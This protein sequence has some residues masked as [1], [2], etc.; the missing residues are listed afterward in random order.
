MFKRSTFKNNVICPVCTNNRG[1]LTGPPKISRQAEKFIRAGYSIV[2]CSN[3]GYYFVHPVIDLTQ[4]EWQHLY[5]DSYFTEMTNWHKKYRLL[6]IEI[7]FSKLKDYC[8]NKI[9]NYLDVGCGEGFGLLEASRRGWS[10]YGIDISDNRIEEAKTNSINFLA[11]DIF[12]AKFPDNLFDCIYMDSVLEHL[13]DPIPYLIELNRIIKKGGILYIGVPDEDSLF[14]AVKKI[15]YR[16]TGNP[17]SEK[18]KPFVT[19]YHVGGFNK[20]SLPFAASEAKFKVIELRNFAAHFEFRKYS[21]SSRNFWLHL[22]LLPVDLTA[23][24][25]GNEIYLEAYLKK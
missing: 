18:I 4:A 12:N 1:V 19:P 7:R 16:L 10:T 8:N 24:L 22:I 13:T 15:L 6:D 11:G 3:C 9:E 23:I 25:F 20:I 14:N 2:Q 17:V 5:D 21:V